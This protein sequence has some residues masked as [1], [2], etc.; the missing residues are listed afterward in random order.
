MALS[1][2]VMVSLV[3]DGG[4]GGGGERRLNSPSHGGRPTDCPADVRHLL[5]LGHLK[6]RHAAA[7]SRPPGADRTTHV[8]SVG[9]DVAGWCVYART[10][11]CRYSTTTICCDI[12]ASPNDRYFPALNTSAAY[13]TSHRSVSPGWPQSNCRRVCDSAALLTLSTHSLQFPISTSP[14]QLSPR[15]NS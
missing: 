7:V 4:G 14:W 12:D 9:C 3:G 8:A 5:S 15:L 6:L 2:S 10:S 1:C 13:S 11:V